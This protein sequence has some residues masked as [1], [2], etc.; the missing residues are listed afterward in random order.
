MFDRRAM[1]AGG[2]ACLAAAGAARAQVAPP[3]GFAIPAGPS[4]FPP[5][6]FA[7]R[8]RKVMDELK[9]GLAVVYGASAPQPAGAVYPPF[10]QDGD[11]AWLTGIVDEP[12]AILV[13]APAEAER[14]REALFLPSRDPETE[15]WDVERVPL[16]ADI[17]RRTG[18]RNVSRTSALGRFVAGAAS[19]SKELRFLGPIVPPSAPVPPALE[20]YGKVVQRLPGARIVDDSALMPR[21]R[22]AKEPREI[23]IMRRAI[24][25]TRRGHLD[26][27]R[28]VRPG[29]TE[30]EL[31]AI[32]EAGFRAGGGQG[33]AYSSIVAAGR[34]A[35]SLHYLGDSGPIRDGDLVLIDAGAHVGGYASDV[36]RTFP[37]SGRF[38]PEQRASYELVLA[39]QDAAVA[40]LKAGVIYDDLAEAAREVFR[41]AGRIDEFYHGLGHFVGLHVHD[42]GDY[43]K[44]LPVGAVVTIEPGLYSHVANSGIRIEDQYLVT[45]IGTERMSVGIPRTVAEIEA[46]MASG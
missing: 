4:P 39:S 33:L 19:R 29:M 26:A 45:A 40:R 35:A 43:S 23:E 14:R 17:E 16:G 10:V 42:A 30:G 32:L 2:V 31:K 7:E 38:T 18:F 36:T 5:E 27:M 25:A 34:N 3:T 20:L 41:R 46:F 28:A 11:F 21:L 1:L 22:S 37:A 12:G 6:V 15:R 24:D 8:R 44:P 9:T 13:L